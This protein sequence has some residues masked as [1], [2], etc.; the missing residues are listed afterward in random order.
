MGSWLMM[1]RKASVC[2][3]ATCFSALGVHVQHQVLR[4][5]LQVGVEVACFPAQACRSS[6]CLYVQWSMFSWKAPPMTIIEFSGAHM[7]TTH[8]CWT[9]LSVTVDKP[10]PSLDLFSVPSKPCW[11]WVGPIQR[12]P[13]PAMLHL[14]TTWGCPL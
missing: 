6:A 10:L 8:L 13:L 1:Y 14:R 12:M 9:R 4:E 5:F 11:H 3:T 2:L 7:G